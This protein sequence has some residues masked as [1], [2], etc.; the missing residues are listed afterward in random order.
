MKTNLDENDLNNI[1]SFSQSIGTLLRQ[2]GGYTIIQIIALVILAFISVGMIFSGISGASLSVIFNIFQTS[3]WVILIASIIL[4]VISYIFIIKLII[5]LKSAEKQKIPFQDNYRKSALFFI[6]GIIVG[7]ILLVV[8]IIATNWILQLIREI[9][10]NPLFEIED[11]E[12]IPSTNII[13][14]LVQVGR[15][16]LSIAGF[17]YLKQNFRQL[18]FCMRNDEKVHKGLQLLVVGYLLLILGSLI[19][20]GVDLGSFL[21][22][23][24]LIITIV[25]YFKASDGLKNTIW[26]N[27]D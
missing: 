4:E 17:Y 13:S 26:S 12:Q 2:I 3:M 5:L 19:G 20:I 10:N 18:S 21:E 16:V 1:R 7:I 22:L 14:T 8:A 25:G 23:A 24:G 27:P 9:F 11:L 6:T 15:I